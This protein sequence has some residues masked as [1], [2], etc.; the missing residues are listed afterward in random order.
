M[1]Y[2]ISILVAVSPSFVGLSSAGALDDTRLGNLLLPAY[3]AMYYASV[4]ASNTTW[5]QTQ[6]LGPRG[7]VV[8]YA[9]HIKNEIIQNLSQKEAVA[10]LTD[11]AGRARDAAREQLNLQVIVGDQSK[12]EQRLVDWCSGY[13]TDFAAKVISEHDRDHDNFLQ[14]LDEAKRQPPKSE[15]D[16]RKTYAAVVP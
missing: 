4:C 6:P 8:H 7:S 5:G 9:E 16:S 14:Q 3:T 13:V 12:H 10:I 2:G 11:A 15:G 1:R